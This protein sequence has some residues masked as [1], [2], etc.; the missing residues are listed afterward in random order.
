MP[1]ENVIRQMSS[2]NTFVLPPEFVDHTWNYKQLEFHSVAYLEFQ[3]KEHPCYSLWEQQNNLVTASQKQFY[4]AFAFLM[5]SFFLKK[6]VPLLCTDFKKCFFL[7]RG[8][9][10]FYFH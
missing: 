7:E 5:S 6:I 2:S 1:D 3:E 4:L 8:N 10:P 9:I